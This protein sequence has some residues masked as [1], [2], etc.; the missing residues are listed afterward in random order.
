MCGS[1]E[2]AVIYQ[3]GTAGKGFYSSFHYRLSCELLTSA[4]IQLVE[5]RPLY[6]SFPKAFTVFQ[7]LIVREYM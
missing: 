6:I 4:Q 3:D 2:N 1:S 7:Y 5:K